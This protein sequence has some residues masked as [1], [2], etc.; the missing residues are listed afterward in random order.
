[1]TPDAGNIFEN[2]DEYG[3]AKLGQSN[4]DD[5]PVSGS[6]Q[7]YV[8]VAKGMTLVDSIRK[9]ISGNEYYD[10]PLFTRQ[11]WRIRRIFP[12]LRTAC[13]PRWRAAIPLPR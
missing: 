8:I 11:M 3:F 12:V 6:Y 2:P 4:G 7:Y 5:L 10:G 1:M 13:L 9:G